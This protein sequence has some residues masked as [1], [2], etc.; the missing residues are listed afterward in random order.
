VA[1]NIKDRAGLYRE[2]ARVLKPDATLCIYDV[3][4]GPDDGVRFPVPW[5]E[6]SEN[7]H[8]TS[9]SEMHDLLH[10]AGFRVEE[11][12]GR[13]KFAIDFFRERLASSAQPPPL[14]LH[15][16]T[17]E[18]SKEKFVNYLHNVEHGAVAPTAMIAKR[19]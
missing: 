8:L 19:V 9:V 16:L 2:I 17:G 14:G 6:R 12:E 11:T 4:K 13:S 15:L 3:M 1:M 18:N 5:A 7:S 10:T